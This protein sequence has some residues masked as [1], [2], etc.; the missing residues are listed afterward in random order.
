MNEQ[1]TNGNEKNL[2]VIAIIALVAISAGVVIFFVIY[3]TWIEQP[4][5]EIQYTSLYTNVPPQAAYNL[6][7]TTNNLSIIDCR[8]REGCGSCQFNNQGHIP[9]AELN[10]NSLTLYNYTTDILVYSKNGSVG[11]GFCQELVNHV[12]GEIYNLEGGFEAW[13]AAGYPLEY[14]S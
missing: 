11:E 9:G 14:G 8:G 6:I 5:N 7:N 1:Q 3:E 10:Q 13:K 2:Q 12:Y 4:S